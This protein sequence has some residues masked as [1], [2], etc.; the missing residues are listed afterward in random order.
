MT[1]QISENNKELTDLDNGE[2]VDNIEARMA[3]LA[4]A[5]D[6]MMQEIYWLEQEIHTSRSVQLFLMS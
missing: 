6:S 2:P 1:D 5:K 3:R 4:L